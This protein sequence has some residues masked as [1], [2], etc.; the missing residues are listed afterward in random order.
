[1]KKMDKDLPNTNNQLEMLSNSFV[2][3]NELSY[4]SSYPPKISSQD[5]NHW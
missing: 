5:S 1:M 4:V 2:P 3:P